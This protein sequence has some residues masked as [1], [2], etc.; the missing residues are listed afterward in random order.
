MG[1][2]IPSFRIAL[3]MEEAEWKP[4]RN[5]LDKSE[6]KKFD[7]MF[8]IPRLYI[9]ACSNS[10][11]LVPFHPIVMSILLHHYK[12]LKECIS[13]VKQIST[14][15]TTLIVDNTLSLTVELKD[16]SKG[17]FEEDAIDLATYSN[18]ESNVLSYVSI[19]E[20]LWIQ[21]E[22]QYR[23]DNRKE[24]Q[25]EQQE[26]KHSTTMYNATNSKGTEKQQGK[27]FY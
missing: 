14:K 16:D 23:V 7:D 25:Q 19:F 1:R 15:V 6:R 13:Q 22:L 11:Q 18:N 10:V 27:L 17:A 8:G 26:Q 9:T 24:P 3:A 2:T 20:M 5:A 21:T 12:Q 4:F